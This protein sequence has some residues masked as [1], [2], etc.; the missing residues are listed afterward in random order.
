MCALDHVDSNN[1]R[2]WG[3]SN[4][5][6]SL[7]KL[8]GMASAEHRVQSTSNTLLST[9]NTLQSCAACR[10]YVKPGDIPQTQPGNIAWQL[11]GGGSCRPYPNSSWLGKVYMHDLY[12][13][14]PACWG[15][16]LLHSAMNAVEPPLHSCLI[17]AAPPLECSGGCEAL[18]QRNLSPSWHSSARYRA[19][20]CQHLVMQA[21]I[22]YTHVCDSCLSTTKEHLAT[23]MYA[24]AWLGKVCLPCRM[25]PNTHAIIQQWPADNNILYLTAQHC[26]CC[27]NMACTKQHAVGVHTQSGHLHL[28][29]PTACS[30]LAHSR[31]A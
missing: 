23:Q 20:R 31:Q 27:F 1:A 8:L 11:A 4:I 2:F 28:L 19:C 22:T 18:I 30:Y 21:G 17:A 29:L 7:D 9:A 3:T 5:L 12:A 16:P 24:H 26:C 13:C 15:L 14:S 10:R 6:R 25:S